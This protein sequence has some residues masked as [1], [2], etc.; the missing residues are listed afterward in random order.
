VGF[1][2]VVIGIGALRDAAEGRI[3]AEER[4]SALLSAS[5]VVAGCVGLHI[6]WSGT[7]TRRKTGN[8][9]LIGIATSRTDANTSSGGVVGI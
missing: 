4:E 8:L 2:F 3:V 9:P 7:W 1:Y 5:V 6:W